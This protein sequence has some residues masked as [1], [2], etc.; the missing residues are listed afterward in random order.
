MKTIDVESF[1]YCMQPPDGGIFDQTDEP[2]EKHCPKCGDLVE[3]CKCALY[4]QIELD[5]LN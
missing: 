3:E 4:D 2:E 5:E 1:Y